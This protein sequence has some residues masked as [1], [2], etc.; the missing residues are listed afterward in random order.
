MSE[1]FINGFDKSAIERRKQRKPCKKTMVNIR[2][3]ERAYKWLKDKGY[4][5]TGVFLEALRLLG[6]SEEDPVED[7][8]EGL[9]EARD[10]DAETEQINEIE[11]ELGNTEPEE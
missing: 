4:S 5:P 1:E 7:S 9:N 2:V 11:R 6:F 3:S 8:G 10:V